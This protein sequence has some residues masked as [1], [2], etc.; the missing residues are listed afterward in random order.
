MRDVSHQCNGAHSCEKYNVETLS[1]IP[2]IYYKHGRVN[3]GF[4]TLMKLM[5]PSLKRRE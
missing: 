1:H 5:L 3:E 4:D 2:E